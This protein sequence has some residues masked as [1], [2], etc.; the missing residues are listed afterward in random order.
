MLIFLPLD[1]SDLE[2]VRRAVKIF[3]TK[4]SPLHIWINNAGIMMND[5]IESKQGYELVMQCNHLGHFY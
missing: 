1:L 5:F 2:S 4:E 3:E